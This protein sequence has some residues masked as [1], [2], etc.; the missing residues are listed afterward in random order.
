MGTR[1]Q[2]EIPKR[3]TLLVFGGLFAWCFCAVAVFAQAPA[4]S[5]PESFEELAKAATAAREAGK[6]EEAIQ[7]YKRALEIRPDWNE[8]W[9]YLGTLEYDTDHYAEAI[10]AF[11]RL[12]QLSPGLGGGWDFLGL[13]EFETKNY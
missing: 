2:A 4:Q 5:A 1:L 7:D 11:Q 13:C 12:T 9:W 10:P 3:A 6:T 8:G